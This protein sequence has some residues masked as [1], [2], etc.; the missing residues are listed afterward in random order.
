MM[1]CAKGYLGLEPHEEVEV[2]PV[3]SRGMER[4]HSLRA[5]T[6]CCRPNPT[7]WMKGVDASCFRVLGR[8]KKS[9]MTNASLERDV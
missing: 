9:T 8:S 6:T 5:E 2:E 7:S 3:V 1:T 4:K